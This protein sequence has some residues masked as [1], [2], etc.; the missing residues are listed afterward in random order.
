MK[1]GLFY[2]G[3]KFNFSK[4]HIFYNE[5]NDCLHWYS[6]NFDTIIQRNIYGNQYYVCAGFEI[7]IESDDN[8]YL[9]WL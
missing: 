4:V 9:G 2:L 3:K 6:K 1:Q 8:I 7:E 5:K